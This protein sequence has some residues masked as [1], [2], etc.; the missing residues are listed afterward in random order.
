MAAFRE[1]AL[2]H[3]LL[4]Q[5][6]GLEIGAAAHN[7]FGLNTRNVAPLDDYGFYASSQSDFG[8]LPSPVHIWATADAIPVPDD[9]EDFVLSSHVVEHLPNL[10][11]AF[12]E[13][14]RIV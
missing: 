11:A 6:R 1:H 7:P 2:A 13:W 12:V 14:N 4:D 5:S 10:I 8:L 3:Q 9:S